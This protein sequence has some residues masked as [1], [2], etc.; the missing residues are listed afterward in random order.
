MS[1]NAVYDCGFSNSEKWFRFRTGAILI[2]NN[3]M[4]F[5]KCDIGNYYYMIGGGVRL[6]ETSKDCIEREVLE[7][8]GITAKADRLTVVCEN[9]FKGKGGAIDGLDCHGIE[10]YYLMDI[11]DMSSLGKATDCGEKLVWL[12]VDEI[13]KSFIKPEFIKER[14][15]EMI[16]SKEIIHI[17]EERDR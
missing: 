11:E 8:T 17:I 10:F 12:S 6:G 16:H 4:L 5:V 13:K 9:F 14:I 15:E 2:N 1:T 3:K 7:E